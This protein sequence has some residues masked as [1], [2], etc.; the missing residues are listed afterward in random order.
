MDFATLSKEPVQYSFECVT[1]PANWRVLHLRCEHRVNAC[2][3]AELLLVGEGE[4][5]DFSAMMGQRVS[6]HLA[7]GAQLQSF[8]GIVQECEAV[9]RSH[10]HPILRLCFVPALAL[11]KKNRGA[12]VFQERSSLE[13]LQELLG[14]SLKAYGSGLHVKDVQRGHKILD[15]RVQYD[16]SDLEF[17]QRI[18]AQAGLNYLLRYDHDLG[19]EVMVLFDSLL[20]C[21]P[22]RNIDGSDDFAYQPSPGDAGAETVQDFTLR[23][24][25]VSSKAAGR[26]WDWNLP[27][28]QTQRASGSTPIADLC[29]YDPG[30]YREDQEGLKARVKDQS[31]RLAGQGK[32]ARGRSH[33]LGMEL[34]SAFSLKEHPIDALNDRYVLTRVLHEGTCL[35][36]GLG[37]QELSAWVRPGPRYQNHFRCRPEQSPLLPEPK[38]LKARAPGPMT[39]L[40]SGP[41]P[42]QVHVD[43]KGRIQLRFHWDI[44][45]KGPAAASCW[46]RVAQAWA[47]DRF[48]LN[49]IPR[50]GTEVVVEFLQG[51]LEQPLVTGCVPN[52]ATMSPFVLPKH[53]YQSGLRTQSSGGA[54]GHNELRFD[55]QQGQEEVYLRAQNAL[56]VEVLG[57]KLHSVAGDHRQIHGANDQLEVS[58]DRDLYIGGQARSETVGPALLQYRDALIQEIGPRG[59]RCESQGDL[60]LESQGLQA[61]AAKQ[62]FELISAKGGAQL[63]L[64]DKLRIQAQ[65]LEIQCGSTTLKINEQGAVSLQTRGQAVSIQGSKIQL[66]SK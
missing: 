2:Y 52:G 33:A 27:V 46:V 19:A 37:A 34:G 36:L 35:D 42:G 40:V 63:Q 15:F 53:K 24:R 64:A 65:A 30:Q 57:A 9:G 12:R 62:G 14:P 7:Q 3:Q 1:A 60:K 55:D 28:G 8:G 25:L 59:W 56:Q 31:L 11:A 18:L 13:L 61:F 16:E 23:H 17:A 6:L 39:A 47:G 41:Q 26:H 66:N 29:S 45:S 38:G 44:H 22:A 32:Q 51:D 58:G 48:G 54:Q 10:G 20:A 4:E 5:H 21:P 49:F 43:D 50:V